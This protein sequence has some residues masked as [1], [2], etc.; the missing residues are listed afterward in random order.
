MSYFLHT[1]LIDDIESVR[2][3][4]QTEGLK[5][6]TDP[7]QDE[8]CFSIMFK[9]H[10]KNLDFMADSKEEADQWVTSLQKLIKHIDNLSKKQTREQYP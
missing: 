7:T 3:G 8:M 9:G 2:K 10:N 1:V 5:K 6:Y 4:R